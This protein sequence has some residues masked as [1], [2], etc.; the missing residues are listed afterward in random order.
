MQNVALCW[1]SGAFHTTPIHWMEFVLGVPL[2]QQKANYMLGNALQQG[3]RLPANHILNQ[4]ATI[5]V[6]HSSS[7]PRQW[8]CPQSDNIWFIKEAVETLLPLL[9]QD[10]VT[11]IGNRLLDNSS[12]IIINIPVALPWASKVYDQWAKA[13]LSKYQL[14]SVDK[15]AISMDGSYKIKGQVLVHLWYSVTATLFTASVSRSLHTH[16][17]TLEY[18]LFMLP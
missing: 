6:F 7:T 8:Q 4:I 3:S 1:I 5:P 14:D 17:M 2:V 18:K 15:M 10:P 16:H 12:R 11:H 13:W 9:L